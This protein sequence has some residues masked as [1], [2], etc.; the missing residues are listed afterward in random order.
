MTRFIEDAL[1]KHPANREAAAGL[2]P[3]V[4]ERNRL[5]EALLRRTARFRREPKPT[6]SEMNAR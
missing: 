4:K 3:E 6:R 1:R 2:L 5:M